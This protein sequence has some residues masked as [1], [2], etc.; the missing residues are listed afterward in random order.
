MTTKKQQSQ[1]DCIK[2]LDTLTHCM[3]EIAD[4]LRSE[5][6]ISQQTRSSLLMGNNDDA[7]AIYFELEIAI[8][9][10]RL[11]MVDYVWTVLPHETISITIVTEVTNK[12]FSYNI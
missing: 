7:V 8:Q 9:E 2:K 10:E 11:Q 6:I 3:R 12:T 1:I 5:K 4:F